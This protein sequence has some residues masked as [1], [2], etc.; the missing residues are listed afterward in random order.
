MSVDYTSHFGP[1][2]PTCA[3]KKSYRARRLRIA[4]RAD[5]TVLV[6]VPHRVPEQMA[7]LFVKVKM[8]WILK[9]LEFFRRHP[10]VDRLPSSTHS[11]GK[12]RSAAWD[13]VRRNITALNK[14]YGFVFGRISVKN[15]RTRW[16]SCS[17]Q[18][19]LN[20]N[21]RLAL[22]PAHLAEYIV[23][24]ELCHLRELN[25]SARFWA[26]VSRTVPDYR[27]RVRELRRWI[28]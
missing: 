5:A 17:K 9:K 13:V 6:T 3:F 26:E 10:Q 11:F 28:L 12:Y 7:R 8:P 20:F 23:A 21:Y 14:V 1:D 25:H 2:N 24:H 18:G 15:Q 22:L 16:G 19:N 4:V 27:A